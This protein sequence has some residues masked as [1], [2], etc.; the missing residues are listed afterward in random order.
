MLRD[1]S[2]VPLSRQHQHALALCVRMDRASPIPG[3]DMPTWQNEMTQH[4]R[5]EIRVHFVAEEQFIF[6]AARAFQ[7]LN[8]L[9]EDLLT[10]HSWL[11]QQFA[12]AEAHRLSPRDVPAFARRLS[13]HIRKE[14]RQLFERLQELMKPDELARIGTQVDQALNDAEQVCALPVKP[15]VTPG[16]F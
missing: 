12:A 1:K 10:D 3:A 13:E 9:V 14:E 11:R 16:Q 4:F 6:P 15:S 8:S 5:A 7:E 2:L